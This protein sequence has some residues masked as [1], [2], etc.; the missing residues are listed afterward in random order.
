MRKQ[1]AQCKTTN[2]YLPGVTW[3]DVLKGKSVLYGEKR[4]RKRTKQTAYPFRC[5]DCPLTC[6]IWSQITTRRCPACGGILDRV[7]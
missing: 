4:R 6:E 5:R 1:H 2:Q 7:L 3:E